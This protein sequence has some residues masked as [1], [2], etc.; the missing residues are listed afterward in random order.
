MGRGRLGLHHGIG[1]L[2][3]G[4]AFRVTD[5]HHGGAGILEHLGGDIAR[6]GPDAAAWQS[7]PPTLILPPFMTAL[8]RRRMV[9]RADKAR[10][11]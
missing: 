6:V 8:A 10:R 7:C 3:V 4:A 1:F 9:P 5:D 11:T 2:V